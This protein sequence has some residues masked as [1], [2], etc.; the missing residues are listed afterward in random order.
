MCPHQNPVGTSPVPHTCPTHL[1][2]D[3]ITQVIYGDKYRS[4]SFR[5][6]PF[7]IAAYGENS[8]K[9]FVNFGYSIKEHYYIVTVHIDAVFYVCSSVLEI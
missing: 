5:S 3:L 9:R 6:S 4:Y 2:L 1:I 7:K 8:I